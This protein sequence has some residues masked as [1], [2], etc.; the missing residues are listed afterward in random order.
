MRLLLSSVV[1]GRDEITLNGSN[2]VLE[3]LAA[4]G[5]SFDAPEVISSEVA[6]PRGFEPLSPP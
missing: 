3:R 5:P 6:S 2:A 4:N 1:V